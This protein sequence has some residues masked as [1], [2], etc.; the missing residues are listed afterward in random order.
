MT[1]DLI[2]WPVDRPM[3]VEEAIAEAEGLAAHASLNIP[4]DRRLDPFVAEMERRYPGIRRPGEPEPP[5]EFDV[6][7]SHVFVGIPWSL[8]EELAAAV[9]DAAWRTGLAV[10]DPQRETVGL[11]RPFAEAPLGADGLDKHV[12]AAGEV[13]DA[14]IGGATLVPDLGEAATLR[15]ISSRVRSLGAVE[16]SPLGF[17][18]TPDIEEEYL[19]DPTRMP[20]S[21]QTAER[22]ASL[23]DELGSSRPEER[24]HAL[25]QLS[26]WGADAGVAAALR[27]L[28]ASDDVF[29]AGFAAHG[30]A[31]QGD[32]SDLPDLV[33]VVRRMSPAD[34]GSADAMLMPL[35]AALELAAL[36]SPEMV[37]AV[38]RRAR[39]WRGASRPRRQAWEGDTDAELDRLLAGE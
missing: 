18:I 21:L 29:E 36:S 17:E 8:V 10:F 9:A 25:V 11:P 23:I 15:A 30:L 34:G 22:R 4:H 32:L 14:V 26:A 12:R 5:C 38:R 6:L 27:P 16:M 1:F 2:V 35:T 13:I 31:R 7:G 39:E 33:D 28:L 24:Q 37:E 19:A 20:G 3:T